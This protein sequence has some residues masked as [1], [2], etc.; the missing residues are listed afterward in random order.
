[1][2]NEKYYLLLLGKKMIGSVRIIGMTRHLEP[3][4]VGSWWGS[5]GDRTG[6]VG[7]RPPGP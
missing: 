1:M 7:Y 4:W 6:G 3:L 5:G 2:K